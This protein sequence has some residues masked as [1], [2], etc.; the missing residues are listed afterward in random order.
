MPKEQAAKAG[1][2]DVSTYLQAVL[3]DLQVRE[4]RRELDAQLLEGARSPTFRLTEQHWADLERQV[5]ERSPELT[6][7]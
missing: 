7:E 2:G 3:R 5:R 1:F 6:D 4:A